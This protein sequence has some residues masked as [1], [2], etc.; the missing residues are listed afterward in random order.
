MNTSKIVFG[1]VIIL[2]IIG[3]VFL[4]K[5]IA[6]KVDYTNSTTAI[7]TLQQRMENVKIGSLLI[8]IAMVL[9]IG[10]MFFPN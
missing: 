9:G 1:I 7:A 6:T 8:V 4:I 2:F 5:G 3:N 10:R